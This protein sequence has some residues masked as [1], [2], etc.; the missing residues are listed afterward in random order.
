VEEGK[1]GVRDLQS[2]TEERDRMRRSRDDQET[3]VDRLNG[4]VRDSERKIS[5][6]ELRLDVM[7]RERNDASAQGSTLAKEEEEL[8]RKQLA[9]MTRQLEEARKRTRLPTG[10]SSA[11]AS[12]PSSGNEVEDLR[13]RLA[14]TQ[15]DLD[16]ISQILE[17]Q[18][19]EP[20]NSPRSELAKRL[21]EALR[22]ARSDL[23]NGSYHF[24]Y[25][26]LCYF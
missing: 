23:A 10:G 9:D 1:R 24:H 2:M 25:P 15:D 11:S 20:G 12:I 14:A 13:S 8:L 6:L 18:E 5:E 16:E 3:E 26:P 17:Q 21:C 19:E 4:V 7:N 22:A